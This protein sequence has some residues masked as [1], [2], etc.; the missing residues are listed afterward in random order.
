MERGDLDTDRKRA[1]RLDPPR[2]LGSPRSDF[3]VVAPEFS[4]REGV[5]SGYGRETNGRDAGGR[6]GTSRALQ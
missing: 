3:D 2:A 5:Q 6:V 1:R 4:G